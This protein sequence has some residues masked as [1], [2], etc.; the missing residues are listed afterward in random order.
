LAS[1]LVERLPAVDQVR[2]TNSGSEAVMM[3]IKAARGFTDRTKIAKFE[4]AYHGSYHY[5]EVSLSSTPENWGSL[6][7]PAASEGQTG[8]GQGPNQ[9]S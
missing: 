1:L 4:G 6:A 2:F 9:T 5:A 7:E 8:I 3:A